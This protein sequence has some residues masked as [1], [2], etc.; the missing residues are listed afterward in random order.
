MGPPSLVFL[1]YHSADEQIAVALKA[2][3]ERRE[4][5][6][7]FF[8]SRNISAGAFWLPSIGEAI[9][10]ADAFLL[11]VGGTVGA[12][13]KLEY[14]E[15]LDRRVREPAF[16]VVPVV[17]TAAPGLPFLRQ[18]HWIT[19]SEP[20]TDPYLANI[21]GA[22][23]G[24][25]ISETKKPWL[26][27]NPYRGL[28]AL[29]EED[30][31]YFFGREDET[32]TILKSIE[33]Q[34]CKL[35]ALIG[36]SGVGKS[37]LVQA[38]VIGALKRQRWPASREGALSTA[39][40]PT[41]LKATRTWAYL[42]M[43][44]GE[45]PIR[46]LTSTF[47][48]LWF[49]ERGNPNRHE[50]VDGWEARLK[51]K[52]CLTE[53]LDDTQAHYA[54]AGTEPPSRVV[55]YIDQGEELYASRLPQ[56]LANRFSELIAQGLSDPRLLVL[57]SQRS[58]YYG[59]LQA[60]AT[61][62]SVT[63]RVDVAP[64]GEKALSTV[65]TEPARSLEVTFESE[66]HV[67]LLIDGAK[68]QPGALPLLADHMSDLW[69]RM[70]E[71]GD[72]LIRIADRSTIVQPGAALVRR[73]DRFLTEHASDL[74]TVKRLFCFQLAYVPREGEPTRRRVP[75]SGRSDAEWRL[76]EQMSGAEWRLLVTS[77]AEGIGQAEIAHEVLLREWP[78]LKRWLLEQREFLAWRGEIEHA[79]RQAELVRKS[80][81]AGALLMGRS[82][83]QAESWVLRRPNDIGKMERA[84]IG[85]SLRK[86][87]QQERAL[88]GIVLLIIFTALASP[89]AVLYLSQFRSGLIDARI[90]SLVV[91]GEIIAGAIA[92]SATV[93]PDTITVDPERLLE[94]QAGQSYE[95]SEALSG[96]EFPINPERVAP[97][98]RRL[99]SPTNTRARVYDRDGVL[100]L[101][102]RNL[103]DVL[104][105]DLPPPNTPIE[106]LGLLE[107]AYVVLRTL[108]SRGTLPL[109]RELAPQNGKGYNEVGNALRG[110][111]SSMVRINDRGEVIVSV[112]VPVQRFR[113]VRGA[114]ML[115]TQGVDIDDMVGAERL[116]VFKIGGLVLIM[117]LLLSWGVIRTMRISRTSRLKA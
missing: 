112:A 58:D 72:G 94:L 11:L 54:E 100:I 92:A 22:L 82:L 37:S 17:I 32:A 31:A 87:R 45:N 40:W 51:G 68:D 38:G 55:L 64:L 53:L 60:N 77:D 42:T 96:L 88:R 91:Q 62:F 81:R 84:F 66:A 25:A 90:Q 7:I 65:L 114:L 97:V 29:R 12:W 110:F 73:A 3:I 2:A 63:E 106:K 99:V 71:R 107:R 39:S 16:P 111:K 61:L 36:N 69:S 57:A 26:T 52:G 23:K 43:R 47:T 93:E 5:F 83:E 109:Y 30:A 27:I 80:H 24:E 48:E 105:F 4:S 78:T 75:R 10:E 59:H 108:A 113:A 1:S 86:R 20:H 6:E 44:P 13:Q 101:D 41:R 21:I 104:R 46:A 33:S 98:L 117:A 49:H 56:Q 19:A 9:R 79:R 103:S 8:A 95:P 18:L 102:S 28:M 116:A 76:I 15:G 50:W 34:P 74:E 89:L 14:Y 115:S 85:E 35:V 67:S 70:Q